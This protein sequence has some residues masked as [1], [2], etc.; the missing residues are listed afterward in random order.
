MRNRS[1]ALIKTKGKR[2]K[3][4]RKSSESGKVGKKKNK[5]EKAKN[6]KRRKV[7]R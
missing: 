2:W 1:E 6:R 7:G 4:K 3:I 5:R